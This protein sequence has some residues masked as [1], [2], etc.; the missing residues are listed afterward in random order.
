MEIKRG[1]KRGRGEGGAGTGRWGGREE[2]GQYQKEEE[3]Y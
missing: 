3:F 2:R 1:W